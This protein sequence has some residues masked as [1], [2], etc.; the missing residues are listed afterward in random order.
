MPS[1]TAPTGQRDLA[2]QLAAGAEVEQVVD[3][4]EARRDRAAEQQRR[5]LRRREAERHR[6]EPARS[7]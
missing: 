6:D 1:A 3:G 7:G 4:A 5:D 2:E